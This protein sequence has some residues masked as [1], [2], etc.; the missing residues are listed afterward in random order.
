MLP[1]TPPASRLEELATRY[2]T[3]KAVH[4]HYLKNYENAFKELVGK[5]VKLLELGIKHGG[6]LFL[7]RDYFE[8]GVIAGL[9]INPVTLNDDSGRIHTYQGMQQDTALLD[10]IAQDVAPD[11]FDVIIDDCS[12]IGILSRSSFWHLFENHLKKGGLYIIEDWGTGY[13]DHWVDGVRYKPGG[14]GFSQPL[15]KVTR[16]LA[17]LQQFP[18]LR[19]LP[20][21]GGLLRAAKASIVR[22]EFHSHDCGMVGFVKELVDELGRPDI[23]SAAGGSSTT[24]KF[25]EMKVYSSHLFIT[26]NS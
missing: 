5:D 12:H 15:Y 16:G 6:S 7:W 19:H 1:Q 25:R 4:V 9:D 10:R 2:N 11:G 21:V 18:S 13:W 20:L 14:K 24:S 8:K 26:K 23:A 22:R 17:R 3:D